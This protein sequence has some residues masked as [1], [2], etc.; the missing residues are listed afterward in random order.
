MSQMQSSATD[1]G[2]DPYAR[3]YDNFYRVER[4]GVVRLSDGGG[5][6][7]FDISVALLMHD[8][9]TAY[10]C[11]AI[12]ETGTFLGDTTVYLAR[13]YSH[14]PV[15]TC[16]IDEQ[17]IGVARRRL[18]DLPNARSECMDSPGLVKEA[19]EKFERPIFY[20]DAH[21][22]VSWPL[23]EELELINNGI[24]CIDDFDIGHPRF[25]Y[26]VYDGVPCGPAQLVPLASRA[27]VYFTFNAAAPL[28]Y[29]CL[30]TGRRAGVGVVPFG[31]EAT[32]AC[33]S[34]YLVRH[35]NRPVS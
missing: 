17:A 31:T 1:T 8:L 22:D 5:P 9:I 4:A 16:D 11:D 14:L 25:A 3:V 20:L 12:I 13:T 2:S 21:W 33:R 28:P 18:R 29:P 23:Q 19:V 24:V 10:G 34:Q 35:A 32:T 15:W 7:G 30:Q 6:F 26:D 27:P